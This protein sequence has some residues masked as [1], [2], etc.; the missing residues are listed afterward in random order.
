MAKKE[1]EER[2]EIMALIKQV[3][4]DGDWISRDQ[5]EV[6]G[7]KTRIKEVVALDFS[8]HCIVDLMGVIEEIYGISLNDDEVNSSETF[9]DVISV[10][11]QQVEVA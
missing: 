5:I 2:R 6:I 8:G 11:V 3:L 1:K 10:V 7:E 9:G 4:Y